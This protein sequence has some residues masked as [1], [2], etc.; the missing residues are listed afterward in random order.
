MAWNLL[1]ITHNSHL[2][3]LRR[4]APMPYRLPDTARC[5][6]GRERQRL[7]AELNN[8]NKL[9]TVLVLRYTDYR[10]RRYFS[11]DLSGSSTRV[12]LCATSSSRLME[13]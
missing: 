12:S 10:R 4:N 7:P 5:H 1:S 2:R 8:S 3:L 11:S 6:H 13:S 9:G